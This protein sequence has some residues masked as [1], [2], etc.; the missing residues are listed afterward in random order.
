MTNYEACFTK[1]ILF[2]DNITIRTGISYWASDS[3][4]I[5]VCYPNI[6]TLKQH[7]EVFKHLFP[8]K[9]IITVNNNKYLIRLTLLFG[10]SVDI[11]HGHSSILINNNFQLLLRNPMLLNIFPHHNPSPIIRSIIN[12]NNM[13][14][15]IILLQ[16]RINIIY[17]T[18]V[19]VIVIAGYYYAEG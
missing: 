14:I 8:N 9:L 10:S 3:N 17:N 13:I 16:Y 5:W 11:R 15:F 18:I 4:K 7:I 2:N 19:C 1:S 12:K 6:V